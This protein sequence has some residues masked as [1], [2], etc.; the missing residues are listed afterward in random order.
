[1]TLLYGARTPDGLLYV[2]QFA[3]WRG[4]G[5][6]SRL[7]SIGPHSVGKGT[8]GV[9]PLLLDRLEPWNAE[10]TALL[11]CGPEVMMTYSV[12]SAA[13]RGASKQKMWVS[14]E[15]NMQCAVGLCGHCQLGPTFV[16]KNGPVYRQDEIE[17]Y[18]LVEGL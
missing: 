15:R 13:R 11:M 9:V 10:R 12:L 17:P 7:R 8:V 1:M 16:C 6:R 18:L 5:F 2:D 3:D 14:L 4:G